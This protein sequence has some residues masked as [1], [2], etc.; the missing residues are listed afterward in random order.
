[1]ADRIPLSLESVEWMRDLAQAGDWTRVEDAWPSEC[2]RPL[3]WLGLVE[4][5][6]DE[7]VFRL[8]ELGS[9]ALGADMIEAVSE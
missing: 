6:G 1:M 8:T 9:W 5:D 7:P 2:F 3:L 4:R